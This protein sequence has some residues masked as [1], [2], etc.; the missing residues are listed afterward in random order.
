M[1]AEFHVQLL[2]LQDICPQ[3]RRDG[4]LT[5]IYPFYFTPPQIPVYGGP[6]CVHLFGGSGL[7][8][9]I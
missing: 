4:C 1:Y 2:Y 5:G 8:G 7:F 9:G 6:R 3:N